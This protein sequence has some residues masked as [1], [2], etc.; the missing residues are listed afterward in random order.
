[1]HVAGTADRALVDELLDAH[2]HRMVPE[3]E[4]DQVDDLGPHRLVEQR[5]GLAPID[6][7]GFVAEHAVPVREREAHIGGVDERGRVH[8]NEVEIGA[9]AHDLDGRHVARRHDLD[10]LATLERRE[11][12]R[13]H[14]RPESRADHADPHAPV[15]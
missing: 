8:G 3:L 4:V 1:M 14:P 11:N 2:A 7:E 5:L 9:A 10:H 15:F 12:G 6:G 13:Y